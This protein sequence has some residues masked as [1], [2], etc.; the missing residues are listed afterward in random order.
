MLSKEKANI[1]L[2]NFENI[3]K[4]SDEDSFSRLEWHGGGTGKQDKGFIPKNYMVIARK[5]ARKIY[6]C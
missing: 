2:D 5:E 3:L 6:M 4:T 1:L